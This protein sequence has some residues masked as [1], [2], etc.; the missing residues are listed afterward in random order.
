MV[1]EN[2][3]SADNQQERPHLQLNCLSN[4]E[5]SETTRQMSQ[6]DDS[7]CTLLGLLYTDGCVSPKYK[8]SWRLNL[9]EYELAKQTKVFGE[10]F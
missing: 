1:S 6:Y 5:S 7:L 8:S 2:V 9:G 3:S 10:L 4:E